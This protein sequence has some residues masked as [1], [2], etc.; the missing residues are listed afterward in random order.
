MMPN[1]TVQPVWEAK[2]KLMYMKNGD[3]GALTPLAG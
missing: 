3:M 1:I 2:A